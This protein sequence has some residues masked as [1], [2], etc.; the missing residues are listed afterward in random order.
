MHPRMPPQQNTSRPEPIRLC[1]DDYGLAPGVGRAIRHLLAMRRLQA[2]SVMVLFPEFDAEI[3]AL[4]TVD[5]DF[6]V[7]LHLTLT[8]HRPLGPMA[9]LAPDGRLPSLG[10]LV[11]LAFAGRLDA[12]E[13][14]AEATRQF[15][16]LAQGLGRRPDFI[17]GH[18]HVQA[19]PV[20]REVVL[21]LSRRTGARLRLVGPP[22]GVSPWRL[23]SP[24]KAAV[25][26]ALGR[27]LACKAG[28]CALN[29]GLLGVRSFAETESY[30]ALFRR[31]LAA[32]RPGTTIMCHPGEPDD[33]LAERDPV[34]APRAEE[35]AYLAGPAFE[36]DLAAAR[37]P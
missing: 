27:G 7:G 12:G 13:I 18:Q 2:T 1:A 14:A 15:E 10:R 9:R 24:L 36:A 33:A 4:G 31:W 6:A 5:G 8:D 30:Q 28:D 21:D 26:A 23:P 34:L 16:R 11:A 29:S 19:L 37:F 25:L 20:V 17:D 3:A 22:P 35:L 32:A